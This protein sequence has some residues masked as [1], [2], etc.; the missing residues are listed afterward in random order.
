MKRLLPTLFILLLAA[1]GTIYIRKVYYNPAHLK[2]IAGRFAGQLPDSSRFKNGDIIFQTSRSSQSQAIRLATHSPYSHCGIILKQNNEYGVLE[3]VEPVKWTP[4]AEWIARGK[5]GHYAV[6]RLKSAKGVLNA[7]VIE[8]MVQAGEEFKGH[9]YDVYFE[10]S[11][12][13][14]YCSELIWKIYMKGAGI[15]IC[16]PEKLRDFDLSAEP[17]RIKMRE[18]YGKHI[19]LNETVV[20]PADIYNS[21]LLTTII[22]K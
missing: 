5:G 14:I 15:E 12:E 2:A 17:V 16:K 19:P 9:Q 18:R 11:D 10:W 1:L 21:N 3:A 13:R 8:K 22:S 20:S 4:L 7:E 6:K